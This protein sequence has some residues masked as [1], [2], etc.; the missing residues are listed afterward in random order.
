MG[1]KNSKAR[2]GQPKNHIEDANTKSLPPGVAELMRQSE[3][4]AAEGEDLDREIEREIA[5]SAGAHAAQTGGIYDEDCTDPEV[6]VDEKDPYIMAQLAALGWEEEEGDGEAAALAALNAQLATLHKKALQCKASGDSVGRAEAAARARLV[7]QQIDALILSPSEPEQ[8]ESALGPKP[9]E[10]SVSEE[11][12]AALKKKAVDLKRAGDKE[13]ALAALRHAK[14]LE[15]QQEG[16]SARPVKSIPKAPDM[17]P[18]T[19][20]DACDPDV[21]PTTATSLLDE[22][23]RLKKLAVELKK[24]GDK[25][26][27]LATLRKVKELDAQRAE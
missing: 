16:N 20:P 2:G 4:L 14:E 23:A 13:G 19:C 3:L 25:E 1:P 8:Q 26:G 10:W 22:I 24:A 21:V 18:S 7:Q 17:M 27:A 6:Q 15:K 5:M 12:V 9:T 11:D